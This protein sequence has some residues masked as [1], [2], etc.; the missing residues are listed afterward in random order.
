MNSPMTT[1]NV[2]NAPRQDSRAHVREDD[3]EE[4]GGPGRAEAF[5][6]FGQRADIDGAQ[7]SVDGAVHVGQ[8][9]RD[10]SAN[11]Q[12]IGCTFVAGERQERTAVVDMQVTNTI[13]MAGI[14]SGNKVMN[15]ISGR[16]FGKRNWTQ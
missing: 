9:Q 3:L 2:R 15:S 12:E 8:T 14:T 16:S 11:Q 7:A 1:A 6:G 4:D 13:T 5:G 10:V